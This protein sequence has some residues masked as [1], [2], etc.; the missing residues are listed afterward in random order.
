MRQSPTYLW[1]EA[2]REHIAEAYSSWV[3]S[4]IVERD[5]PCKAKPN[6]HVTTKDL[7]HTI[8]VTKNK[9]KAF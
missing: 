6:W 8:Q 4:E 9:P 1:L 2:T 5:E 3:A 7:Q